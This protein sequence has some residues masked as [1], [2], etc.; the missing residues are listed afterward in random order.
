MIFFFPLWQRMFSSC[1]PPSLILP[2]TLQVLCC[3]LPHQLTLEWVKKPLSLVFYVKFVF[4]ISGYFS[5][6]RAAWCSVPDPTCCVCPELLEP[7]D[8]ALPPGLPPLPVAAPQWKRALDCGEA[9]TGC[10]K[11]PWEAPS[12]QRFLLKQKLGGSCAK[13]QGPS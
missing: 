1:L 13:L 9:M 5:P 12:T 7:P 4:L 2:Y 11:E 6:L 3:G 8:P 10:G